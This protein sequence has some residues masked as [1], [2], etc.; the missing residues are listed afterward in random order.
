MPL[1]IFRLIS[2]IDALPVEWRESL[3]TLHRKKIQKNIQ[4]FLLIPIFRKNTLMGKRAISNF[5]TEITLMCF[6]NLSG[7]LAINIKTGKN[8]GWF[9]IEIHLWDFR[10]L[11]TLL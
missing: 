4:V 3:N 6:L 8:H 1:D 5:S 9:Y 2:V 10:E 7:F 11:K